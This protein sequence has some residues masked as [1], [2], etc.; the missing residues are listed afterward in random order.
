MMADNKQ[1]DV[2]VPPEQHQGG[3]G[4]ENNDEVRSHICTYYPC[5]IGSVQNTDPSRALGMRLMRSWQLTL[6]LFAHRKRSV[7]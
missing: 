6:D 5:T 2:E 7:L 1:D 3:A 4:D